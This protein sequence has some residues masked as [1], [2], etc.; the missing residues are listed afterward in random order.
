MLVGAWVAAGAGGGRAGRGCGRDGGSPPVSAGRRLAERGP[1]PA[2]TELALGIEARGGRCG[3]V[4][5]GAGAGTSALTVR[6]P[7]ETG[8][9]AVEISRP[10]QWPAAPISCTA[11]G[12]LC[13]QRRGQM[14][15]EVGAD[16]DSGTKM[17][18]LEGV[19]AFAR[20]APPRKDRQRRD[21]RGPHVDTTHQHDAAGRCRSRRLFAGAL[22]S[23]L[24]SVRDF[25][26]PEDRRR[27]AVNQPPHGPIHLRKGCS[28]KAGPSG[29]AREKPALP[30]RTGTEPTGRG[31]GSVSALG[32]R[33]LAPATAW[34]A[35]ASD[36]G[37]PHCAGG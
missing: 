4:S 30:G 34:A 18:N 26:N 21:G 14:E 8:S 9:V 23:F 35:Q 1:G 28:R 15:P 16:A 37:H 10:T 19:E 31:G 7:V 17:F 13:E 5:N 2:G 22:F 12:A 25:S 32:T 24:F 33:T 29:L 3:S 27:G 11:N 6:G 36:L 20:N